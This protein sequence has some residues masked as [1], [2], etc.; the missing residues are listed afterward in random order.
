[1]ERPL[2][3][4]DFDVAARTVLDQLVST[5]TDAIER[6]A[7]LVA[8]A[9]RA[10]GVLQAFGTG[11]SRAP[12]MELAGRAGGLVPTNRISISDLAMLGGWDPEQVRDPL[13]ERDPTVAAELW[14]LHDIRDGDVM[15]IASNS[16]CN[17][18]TVEMG[19][20]ATAAGLPVIAITSVTHSSMMT[21]RHPSGRRL[22]DEADVVIDNCGPFG[23]AVLEPSE[24]LRVCGVSTVSSTL[25]AQM[26]VA[27]VVGLLMVDGDAPVYLS[28]N[29]PGGDEHNEELR[30]R[31][32]G[33]IR[34]G[35]A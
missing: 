22:M 14:K 5:Q 35:E 12:A 3:A 13:I 10:G 16:G 15:V 9:L 6:A 33:R 25:A 23:D 21:S 31:Y 32:A 24:G 20:L 17:S 11:H 2:R 18:S 7:V 27:E 28:A 29:I 19:R 34:P 8:D 26:M 4:K 1:M 30:A